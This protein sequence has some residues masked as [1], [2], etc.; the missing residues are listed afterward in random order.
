MATP[1]V[2]LQALKFRVQNTWPQKTREETRQLLIKTAK[3]GH[4]KI[5]RQQFARE[6]VFPTWYAYANTYTNRNI[7]NVKLPGPIVY[8]YTYDHEMFLVA[9]RYLTQMSPMDTGLYKRSH[10]LFINDRP[11]RPGTPIKH[12]DRIFIANTVIYARRLEIGRRESGQPFL[13]SVPNRIYESV[14]KKIL[15]PR[16]RN[17]ARISMG[18]VT[19]PDAYRAK[20]RLGPHYRLPNGKVR[21]RRQKK[22][23]VRQ[24]AI[25]FEPL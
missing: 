9:L 10:T 7:E 1:E 18:Y 8:K 12:G 24:P 6:H 23:L 22:E 20:G 19:L 14:T 2:A 21:K 3:A 13:M 11:V 16:Y 25:F 17:V 15:I 4:D 5:M